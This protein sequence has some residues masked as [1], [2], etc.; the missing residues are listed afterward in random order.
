MKHQVAKAREAAKLM[1][2]IVDRNVAELAKVVLIDC[3][4]TAFL[5]A[6]RES[7]GI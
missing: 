7:T 4:S 3:L 6:C 5:K 1:P 2:E